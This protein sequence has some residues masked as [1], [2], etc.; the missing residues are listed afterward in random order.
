M[1]ADPEFI[2]NARILADVLALDVEFEVRDIERQ[3]LEESFDYVLSLNLLH[4][5]R[6]PLSTLDNFIARAHERLV[7]EVATIGRHDRP[8]LGLSWWAARSLLRLPII[9]VGRHDPKAKRQ[10]QKFFFTPT[11]IE[12]LLLHQRGVFARGSVLPTEHKGRFIYLADKR[13]VDHLLFVSGPTAA[14]KRTFVADLRAGKLPDV[15]ARIGID[16]EDGWKD[17]LLAERM[18]EPSEPQQKRLIFVMD[19]LRPDVHR[20][21]VNPRD[22][23]LDIIKTAAKVTFVTLWTPPERLS[24]QLAKAMAGGIQPRRLRKRYET[25]RQ[26]YAD[27]ERVLAYHRAWNELVSS[28]RADHFI[29]STGDAPAR[30]LSVDEW[31]RLVTA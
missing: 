5:L 28:Q 18:H 17:V 13:K 31:E 7:L 12:N 20:P 15:A 21:K 11:A 27:R 30:V 24:G 2:R 19:F 3:P 9:F 22:V 25:I 10:V 16:P 1:D 4:H 8:K 26:D 6:N 23:T 29:V 14:G